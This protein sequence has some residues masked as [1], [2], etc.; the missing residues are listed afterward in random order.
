MLNYILILLQTELLLNFNWCKQTT[1]GGVSYENYLCNY[2][3]LLDEDKQKEVDM[4]YS[5]WDYYSEALCQIEA[6]KKLSKCEGW[7]EVKQV[8]T[9]SD[10]IYGM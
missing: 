7:F 8:T 6:I 4:L 2:S 9:Y 5:E 3:S 1:E 10:R